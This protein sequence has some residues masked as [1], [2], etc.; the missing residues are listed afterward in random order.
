MSYHMFVFTYDHL[1]TGHIIRNKLTIIFTECLPWS[2][3]LVLCVCLLNIV[4]KI[5]TTCSIEFSP[6]AMPILSLKVPMVSC[7]FSHSFSLSSPNVYRGS[8]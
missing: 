3:R 1:F 4:L 8:K 6:K 2:S 5:K 7:S